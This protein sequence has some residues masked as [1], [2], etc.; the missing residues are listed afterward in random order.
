M[1]FTLAVGGTGSL[2]LEA[3]DLGW[4]VVLV[5]PIVGRSARPV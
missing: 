1:T 5:D 3:Q 2:G 4:L